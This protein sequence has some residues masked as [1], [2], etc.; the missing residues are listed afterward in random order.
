MSQPSVR[1]WILFTGIKPSKIDRIKEEGEWIFSNIKIYE[2][3]QYGDIVY[4]YSRKL[5]QLKFIATVLDAEMAFTAGVN[6]LNIVRTYQ[7]VELHQCD[8]MP[9]DKNKRYQ[10]YD[11]TDNE[12][13]L[14]FI[15]SKCGSIRKR[16]LDHSMSEYVQSK[17]KKRG[18]KELVLE[19]LIALIIGIVAVAFFSGDLLF[20]IC[21]FIGLLGMTVLAIL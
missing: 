6:R 5:S 17:R 19:L 1:I 4:V 15:D 11:I 10:I 13:L 16:V 21:A 12:N 8:A 7:D 2:Q 18:K 3:F 20:I 9:N 14:E